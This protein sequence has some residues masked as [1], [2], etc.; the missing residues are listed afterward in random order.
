MHDIALLL[1]N[2]QA[3][4]GIGTRL[5]LYDGAKVK[6]EE[7]LYEKPMGWTSAQLKRVTMRLNCSGRPLRPIVHRPLFILRMVITTW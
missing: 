4:M 5:Q 1:R 6:E 7:T 2:S 3:G